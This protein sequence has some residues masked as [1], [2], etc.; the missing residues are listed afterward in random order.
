VSVA[1]TSA[2][3]SAAA[4]ATAIAPEPVPTS[5][6]R[7]GQSPTMATAASTRRSLAGLGVMT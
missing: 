2:C 6:I 4:S 3:G 5:A 7:A 1:K